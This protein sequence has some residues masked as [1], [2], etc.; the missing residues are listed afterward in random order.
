VIGMFLSNVALGWVTIEL[1]RGR[2]RRAR[3]ATEVVKPVV[4]AGH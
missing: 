3:E 4:E 1:L 2:A